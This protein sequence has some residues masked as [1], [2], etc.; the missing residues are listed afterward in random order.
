MLICVANQVAGRWMGYGVHR[1][2][3]VSV[4]ARLRVTLSL[5]WFSLVLAHGSVIAGISGD[6]EN[7]SPKGRR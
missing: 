3:S 6:M 1:A 7:D 2:H 5:S 4:G